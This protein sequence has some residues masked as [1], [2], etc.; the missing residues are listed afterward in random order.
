MEMVL[1]EMVLVGGDG[2]SVAV[3]VGGEGS[4]AILAVLTFEFA[5][6]WAGES[7]RSP[8]E[9]CEKTQ[10]HSKSFS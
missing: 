5:S 1:V 4:M 9:I 6:E 2:M 10:K 8:G 3:L 7:E